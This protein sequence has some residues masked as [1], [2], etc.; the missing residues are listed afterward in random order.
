MGHTT[1][2][3]RRSAAIL[4][5]TVG[6]LAIATGSAHAVP[7]GRGDLDFEPRVPRCLAEAE[8]ERFTATPNRLQY[9]EVGRPVVLDW[10]IK[11]PPIARR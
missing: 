1:V 11:V 4:L 2:V 6:V 5:F 9:A 10:S 3:G 8:L 7:G